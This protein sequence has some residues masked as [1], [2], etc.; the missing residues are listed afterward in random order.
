[1]KQ[2]NMSRFF[3]GLGALL[4]LVG[5]G[6]GTATKNS[7]TTTTTTPSATTVANAPAGC[8]SSNTLVVKSDEAGTEKP[9]AANSYAMQWTGDEDSLQL[10]FADYAVDAADVYGA[11]TGDRMLS[12]IRLGY[13]DNAT[14]VAVGTYTY[15]TDAPMLVKEFNISTADLAGGVFDDK[16]TVEITYMG[17]DYICG[18]VTATDSSSS[19]NGSF[20]AKYVLKTL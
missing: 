10:V 1:M 17:A 7:S 16:G 2:K 18:T 3:V 11:I 15:V 9:D 19:I 6:C 14:P 5:A 8:A 20:I 4:L 13:S 12:V